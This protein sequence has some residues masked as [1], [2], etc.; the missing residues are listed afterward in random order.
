MLT[1]AVLAQLEKSRQLLQPGQTEEELRLF[2]DVPPDALDDI[3]E[4]LIDQSIVGRIT[5][6][7]QGDKYALICDPATVSVDRV[8]RAVWFDVAVLETWCGK[9]GNASSPLTQLNDLFLVKPRLIDWIGEK[10][11]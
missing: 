4:L 9:M 2:S 7:E 3:L 8:A 5:S 11:E 6:D 10:A 1:L